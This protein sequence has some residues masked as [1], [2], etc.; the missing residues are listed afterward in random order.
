MKKWNSLLTEI[1]PTADER[2]VD[3][4]AETRNVN[5]KHLYCC[6]LF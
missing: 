4:V 2:K 1:Q 3:K 5:F 6:Q